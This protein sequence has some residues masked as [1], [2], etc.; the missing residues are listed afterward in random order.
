M[1][2]VYKRGTKDRP[3]YYV[4]FKDI[5]GKWKGKPTGQPTKKLAEHYAA[6]VEARIAR[7]I[8]GIPQPE[9]VQKA[10]LTVGQ[11]IERFQA[12][13]V[14]PKVRKLDG[15]RELR[16][17]TYNS[18]IRPY[19]F[20]TLAAQKVRPVDIENFRDALRAKG[21]KPGTVNAT[22]AIV[23]TVFHWALRHELITGR[24]PCSDVG[25]LAVEPL[26]ERYTLDEVHRLLS[27]PNLPPSIAMALYTGMRFG[28]LYGLRWADIDFKTGRIDV[29]H[30]YE[31]PT[32]SG[33]PRVVPIHRELAPILAAWQACCPQTVRG[34]VFPVSFVDMRDAKLRA[35]KESD[36][37]R[38]VEM[39]R[40]HL[41]LAGCRAD[42]TRPWHAFRHTFASLFLEQGGA[43]AALERILG[44]STSGN[45]VTAGYVHV[46]LAYLARELD[47]MRLQ[48]QPEA[49][50]IPLRA[51]A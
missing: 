29:R 37:G 35:A 49:R 22:L 44:H 21:Y 18:R 20:S 31:G 3:N 6:E 17:T 30:S 45:Q 51:T 10:A 50:I 38:L 15:Y 23:K 40:L 28:E 41:R 32:K 12:E 16:R 47:R 5:D 39:L 34:L 24:N 4:R 2:S 9:E 27:L 26:E 25:K 1:A 7:G 19:P 43:Q 36:S 42:F 8:I 46:D 33:K 13:C 14:G 48:P 11:L